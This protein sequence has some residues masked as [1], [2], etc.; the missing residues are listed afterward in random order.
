MSP[1]STLSLNRLEEWDGIDTLIITAGV[2]ALQPLMTVAGVTASKD[3]A[4]L[5]HATADAINHAV[6]VAKAAIDGNFFGPYIAAITFVR[7][8]VLW[9]AFIIQEFSRYLSSRPAPRRHLFFSSQVQQQSYL[10]QHAPSTPPPNQLPYC[11][12]RPFQSSTP[13]SHSRS[14]FL[15]QSRVTSALPQSIR[16]STPHL[17]YTKLIRTSTACD[18]GRW[19]HAVSRL[20]IVKRRRLLCPCTCDLRMC[21]IGSGPPMWSGE[22]G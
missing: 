10:P 11:C 18:A 15:E 6:G 14:S 5:Q 13:A 2:S 22:Q 20:L 21:C 9:S 8:H 16:R 12:F 7:F 19:R 3:G 4:S 1:C 17:S